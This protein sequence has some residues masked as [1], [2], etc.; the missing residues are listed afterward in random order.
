MKESLPFSILV[1][2]PVQLNAKYLI[3][4][5]IS[6]GRYI[7]MKF[8]IGKPSPLSYSHAIF[9]I[10]FYWNKES[11][12]LNCYI[13]IVEGNKSHYKLQSDRINLPLFSTVVPAIIFMFLGRRWKIK[14]NWFLL[15]YSLVDLWQG[16]TLI[17]CIILT[18]YF[19]LLPSKNLV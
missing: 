4:L 9:I 17:I 5:A 14:V 8:L 3:Y 19:S 2:C 16:L 6:S 15:L 1:K 13:Y 18:D 11:L 12:R 10:F 7:L